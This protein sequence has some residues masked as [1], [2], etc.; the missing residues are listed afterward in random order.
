VVRLVTRLV[1][2]CGLRTGQVGIIS[3]YKAQ[4][5]LLARKLPFETTT[6]V[7]GGGDDDGERG[8]RQAVLLVRASARNALLHPAPRFVGL[9]FPPPCKYPRPFEHDC[10]TS[11]GV[12]VRSIKSVAIH[13]IL[14]SFCS[15]FPTLRSH[16][17]TPH[18]P[19]PL[20]QM[21]LRG[22]TCWSASRWTATRGARRR[23]SCSARCAATRGAR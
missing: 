5:Q 9:Q 6:K 8:M 13:Q 14:S 11:P 21:R 23:S 12:G 20:P 3:P 18:P 1:E 10:H 17:D 4:V 22:S 15:C 16:H 7:G 2:R 19:A